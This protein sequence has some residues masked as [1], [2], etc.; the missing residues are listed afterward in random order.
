MQILTNITNAHRPSGHEASATDRASALTSATTAVKAIDDVLDLSQ[1]GRDIGGLFQKLG[2]PEQDEFLKMLV[3]LL[4]HGIV[5]TE[6][7][8]VNGQP[9]ETFVTTRIADPELRHA[10]PYRNTQRPTSTL[11]LH[12]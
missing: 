3:R 1:G 2:A 6:T 4:Q 8:E 5:G 9:H 11:D 7:L 12:G 10:R